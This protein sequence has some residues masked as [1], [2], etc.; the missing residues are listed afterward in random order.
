MTDIIATA[1][2]KGARGFDCN[3]VVRTSDAAR[4]AHDGYVFAIRYVPRERAH[5]NDITASEFRALIDAGLGV[6]L[7]QHVESET[8][9]MPDDEKARRYGE[10]AAAHAHL[11]GYPKGATLWLD[12]EGVSLMATTDVVA[13]YCN[14]WHDLVA[15]AGYQPGIYVGWHAGLNADQLYRRLRFTRY[16]AAYNLNRD[17][18]PASRGVC[19]RQSTGTP[20]AGVPFPIDDNSVT[21]DA[22]GGLPMIAAPF[23]SL[24]G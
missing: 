10:T 21:G 5:A 12:L 2:P 16:W 13:R 4:F 1:A 19:M 17:Q 22:F 23:T 3:S 7:V 9:W 6:M 11:V 8:S 14:R 18:F 20:P 24:P 15:A